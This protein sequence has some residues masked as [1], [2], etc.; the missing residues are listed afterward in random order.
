MMMTQ[1][2]DLSGALV[3]E[4]MPTVARVAAP[5]AFDDYYHISIKQIMKNDY[6]GMV[7]FS[8]SGE[9]F[10]ALIKYTQQPDID[11]PMPLEQLL[12]MLP[13]NHLRHER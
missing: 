9:Y 4:R 8:P 7:D 3:Q 1:Y 5:R 13:T 6:D 2:S 10:Y 12:Q 11:A